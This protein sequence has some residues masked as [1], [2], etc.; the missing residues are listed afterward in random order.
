[1]IPNNPWLATDPLGEA[2]HCLRMEGAFYCRSECSAP[3]GVD[4]PPIRDC[5]LLH[6]VIAGRCW[7][8]VPG[9]APRLLQAG[10]LALVP[11]GSGHVMRSEPGV[12]VDPLFDL[13]RAYASGRYEVIRHGGGGEPT[14]LMCAA[15]RFDQPTA[16]QLVAMLP[17]CICVDAS[18]APYGEWM[19]GTLRYM[20]VEAQHMRPGGE[21][22]VTRLADIL[23]IQAIRGW[24]EQDPAARSGW[25][26]ALQ[27]RHVGRA[28]AAIHRDP[29]H[30]WTLPLLAAEANM[31]RSAFAARFTE[32]LG[33]PPMQYVAQWRMHEAYAR[34]KE[35]REGVAQLAYS[36]GYQSEAAFSRA[37]KRVIGKSPGAVA[38]E[39]SPA[40]A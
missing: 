39:G 13:P 20:A 37:F 16:R 4:L 15:V 21:A 14:Q 9:E 32:L 33:M 29:A 27:D 30:S 34:L 18:R 8:E 31:S 23:V 12:A 40:T 24:I 36:L 2:L 3:W 7:L 28:I 25:L 38:R 5:L 19:Q 17:A 11:H 22:V 1:M 35:N 6:V 10:D 26:F